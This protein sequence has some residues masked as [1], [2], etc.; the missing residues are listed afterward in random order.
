M[1]TAV[2]EDTDVGRLSRPATVRVWD[3][4]VRIFHWSLVAA[5]ATAW[6]SG[7]EDEALHNATG[8]V[9]VGLVALRLI[10]GLV[11][12][13]HARFIDFLYHP[14]T[15]LDFIRDSLVLRAKRYVGHNPAGGIMVVALLLCLAAVTTT[16]IMMTTD[17]YWGIE[18]VRIAHG[19][20]IDLLLLLI[21][22]HLIGVAVASLEHRENLVK[23]MVTGRKRAPEEGELGSRQ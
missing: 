19:V 21:A 20:S 15:I 3:P 4:L 8:Y 14:S 12:S 9:V 1:S 10:W 5:V 11:G 22:I 17:A 23:A 16:G 13:R 2:D 7:G 6:L 18:W